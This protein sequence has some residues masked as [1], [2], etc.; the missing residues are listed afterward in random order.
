MKCTFI[1]TPL[2]ENKKL[3]YTNFFLPHISVY[4]F[5]NGAFTL[6]Q[7]RMDFD[8]PKDGPIKYDKR[9]K[10]IG[11]LTLTRDYIV[12]IQRD[13]GKDPTDESTVG[14]DFSK[15]SRNLLFTILTVGWLALQIWKTR[16][17]E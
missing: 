17:S 15:L 12:C 16:F 13:Y 11:A 10:G 2:A 4:N 9:R 7:E 5:K 3:V 1:T 6:S 14:R 8:M